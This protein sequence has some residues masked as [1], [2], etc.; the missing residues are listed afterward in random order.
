MYYRLFWIEEGLVRPLAVSVASPLRS[1][2]PASSLTRTE[3]QTVQWPVSRLA[4]Q[5]CMRGAI[6]SLHPMTSSS[7]STSTIWKDLF[8]AL[9]P[10]ES[11]LEAGLGFI[12][13]KAARN[14]MTTEDYQARFG[15]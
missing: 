9:A 15:F 5:S 2:L 10:S 4:S 11:V 3:A 6:V 14:E 1:V 12:G 7:R 13:A 8:H